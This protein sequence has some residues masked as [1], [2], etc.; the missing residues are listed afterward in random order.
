MKVGDRV[1]ADAKTL[2]YFAGDYGGVIEKIDGDV[3]MVRMDQSRHLTPFTAAQIS[4]DPGRP[5]P[6]HGSGQSGP[7][8]HCTCC[9]GFGHV[10]L[11]CIFWKL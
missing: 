3:I 9:G 1:R 5:V 11:E 7:F 4:L 8:R 6:P 10:K 2:A